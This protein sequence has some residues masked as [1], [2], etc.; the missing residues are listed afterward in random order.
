MPGLRMVDEELI[1]N[2]HDNT[3]MTGRRISKHPRRR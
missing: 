3:N 2:A 1:E